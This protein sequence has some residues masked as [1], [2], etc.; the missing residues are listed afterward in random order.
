[1]I[2]EIKK[3]IKLFNILKIIKKIQI[4]Y[5]NCHLIR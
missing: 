2:H 4:N 5:R 3:V 1:M